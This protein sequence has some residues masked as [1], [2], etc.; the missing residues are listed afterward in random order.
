M[1]QAMVLEIPLPEGAE[2]DD[3]DL[4]SVR[5]ALQALVSV[6]W[7]DDRRWRAI[8]RRLEAEGWS[9]HAGLKWCAE[10]RRGDQH[11]QAP[12]STRLEAYEEL[13][14]LTQLDKETG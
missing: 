13:L 1:S 9:V 7:E 12:G 10:A 8:R 5:A 6:R 4:E 11:E 3:E 2:A 14:T